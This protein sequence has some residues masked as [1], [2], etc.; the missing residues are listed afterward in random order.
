MTTSKSKPQSLNQLTGIVDGGVAEQKPLP[1]ECQLELIRQHT[2]LEGDVIEGTKMEEAAAINP[3][4][5]R[6]RIQ[7]L[8][9]EHSIRQPC[10]DDVEDSCG[11]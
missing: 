1:V 10:S 7:P 11:R 9:L 5:E 2:P 6:L 4:S 8:G 3:S